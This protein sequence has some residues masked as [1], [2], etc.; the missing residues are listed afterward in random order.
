MSKNKVI[1]M[2]NAF[3]RRAPRTSGKRETR[4]RW[5]VLSPAELARPGSA[6]LAALL[7]RANE[8]GQ[9]LHELAEALGVTYGYI[10]QLRSGLR[11]TEHISGQFAA[12]CAVYLRVPRIVVKLLAGQVTVLDFLWP[13]PERENCLEAGLAR[14]KGDPLLGSLMPVGVERL[15]DE[16]RAFIIMCYEQATTQEVIPSRQLPQV[17]LDLQHAA[18]AQGE[19][20]VMAESAAGKENK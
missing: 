8:L 19:R 17:L 7:R 4:T 10:Q 1:S 14:I 2:L 6:L 13:G 9:K 20:D 11:R 18:I 5:N 15:D 16:I 12:A 3:Q